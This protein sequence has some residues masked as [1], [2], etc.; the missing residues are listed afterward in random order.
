MPFSNLLAAFAATFTLSTLAFAEPI[1]FRGT[2][3]AEREVIAVR[4]EIAEAE[5]LAER[6]VVAEPEAIAERQINI[7]QYC[8]IDGCSPFLLC[9]ASAFKGKRDENGIEQVYNQRGE[10]MHF[11]SPAK[12]E[13][14]P[15]P[16]AVEL[17]TGE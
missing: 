11:V 3:V 17:P 6:E 8:C 5:A 4:Q 9:C 16:A 13:P 12:T 15:A 2:Q 7:E 14:I 1:P 10:L